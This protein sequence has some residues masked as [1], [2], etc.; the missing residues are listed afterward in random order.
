VIVWEA[1][2]SRS[3]S[4]GCLGL[5]ATLRSQVALDEEAAAVPLVAVARMAKMTEKAEWCLLSSWASALSTQEQ[6]L[7]R[8][9]ATFRRLSMPFLAS[10][11]LPHRQATTTTY[12]GLHRMALGS[13]IVGA[14]PWAASTSPPT[15]IARGTTEVT[16]TSANGHGRPSPS[17]PRAR[18][19]L[20]PRQLPALGCRPSLLGPLH[21]R[22][23]PRPPPP[24]HN[25][26]RRRGGKALSEE[27]LPPHWRQLLRSHSLSSV[28]LDNAG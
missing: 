24:P 10:P 4:S 27:P 19:L 26:Q 18:S 17:R 3:T 28:I 1:S 11:H 8:M 9:T 23:R 13:A 21:L 12:C 7:G 5:A 20:P 16:T 14:H 2:S 25:Q 6:A 22:P 15:T